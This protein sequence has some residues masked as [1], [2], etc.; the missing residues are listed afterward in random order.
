MSR[1]DLRNY[2]LQLDQV[3]D[4]LS[5]APDD[6]ELLSL[7]EELT[8]LIDL[9]KEEVKI[10]ETQQQEAKNRKWPAK[11]KPQPQT[12]QAHSPNSTSPAPETD[13]PAPASSSTPKPE[14]FKVGDV[15]SAKWVSGDGAFY[16]A[17]I[18]QVTGLSTKPNYTVKFL[19]WEDSAMETVPYYHVQEL[20]EHQKRKVGA[21]GFEKPPPPKKIDPQAKEAA[22][23]KKRRKLREKQELER[24]KQNWQSFAAKGPKKRTGTVGK[25]APIGSNSMFK[26]PEAYGG[27]GMVFPFRWRKQFC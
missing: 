20:K 10:D 12:Q 13:S 21:A 15:V 16:A 1:D 19:K 27:R 22:E 23:E 24:T 9:M 11:A 14:T 18:T 17:K 26:T 3:N 7:K 8:Q 2:Q 6:Q 25:A 4:G 5:L